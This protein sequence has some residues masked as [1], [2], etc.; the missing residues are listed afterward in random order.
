MIPDKN[1]LAYLIKE[2]RKLKSKKIGE[3]YT[4]KLL[5]KDIK[6]SQSYIGD[7]ESGRTYP[8]IKMLNNIAIACEVPITFFTINESIDKYLKNYIKKQLPN[9]SDKDL[10]LMVN[11]LKNDPNI[12]LIDFTNSLTKSVDDSVKIKQL[13]LEFLNL[14]EIQ[15]ISQ[16]NITNLEEEKINSLVYDIVSQIKLVSYKYLKDS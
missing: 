2:A 9:S 16:V 11:S 8:S 6:K 15:K 10:N 14:P 4:Q 12:K 5:A 1:K 3:N 7:I 13:V